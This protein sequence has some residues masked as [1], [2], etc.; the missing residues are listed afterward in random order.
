MSAKGTEPEGAGGA[1]AQP[2]RRTTNR[3]LQAVCPAK[4][5]EGMRFL[6]FGFGM[7]LMNPLHDMPSG[8]RAVRAYVVGTR[9]AHLAKH[10]TADLH[11]VGEEL[12][13]HAP[14]A[15]VPGAALDRAHR[16]AGDA[17]EQLP[18]LLSH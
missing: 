4:Q 9:L 7:A 5:G 17:F 18:R 3:S 13:L 8:D 12:L 2:A 16:R 14:G 15:V 10:R 1:A 11:R 6:G